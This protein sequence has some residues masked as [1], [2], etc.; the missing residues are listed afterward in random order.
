M[1]SLPLLGTIA[2]IAVIDSLN[3]SLFVGQFVIFA[4]S[5]PVPRTLAYIGGIITA[6][7]LGGVLLT[8][9]IRALIGGIVALISPLVMLAL[10]F[11]IGLGLVAFGVIYQ[12][13]PLPA[14]APD[15]PNRR[16]RA[17]L[18]GAFIFGVIVMGNELTTALPYFVAAE[19]IAAAE[20][21]LAGNLI[22]LAIYNLVFALPLFGFLGGFVLVRDRFTAQIE[23][24]NAWVRVWAPRITRYG[25]LILGAG[26]ILAGLARVAGV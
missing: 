8:A 11:G 25:A 18:W 19:R 22:V 3:P 16:S 24:I 23:R 17:G 10:Q 13:K 12:A 20:L 5:R 1:I 2:G 4:T 15:D 26:L 14:Q 7:Y 6:N 21:G 9:G